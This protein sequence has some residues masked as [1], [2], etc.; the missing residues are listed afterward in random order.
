MANNLYRPRPVLL[1]DMDGPLANFD[2]ALYSVCQHLGIELNIKGLDDPNRKY[3]MTDNMVHANEK[4]M[5]RDLLDTSHFFQHI[6][7]TDGAIEGVKELRQYFDVWICTKPLDANQ[8]CRDDKMWWIKTYFPDL[9]SKVIMTPKKSLVQGTIL[10]DDA[11]DLDCVDRA[12]WKPVVFTD[13]FNG[14]DSE[15]AHLPHW[16]WGDSIHNLIDRT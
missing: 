9:Y 16:S 2:Q 14:S 4:L 13:Q 5:I 8:F 3:Y 1:L 15:W 7:V 6:P 12:F 11:P 10:L